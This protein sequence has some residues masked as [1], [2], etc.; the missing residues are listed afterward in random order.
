MEAY[1]CSS[2]L[3]TLM[4]REVYELL[5]IILFLFFILKSWFFPL[6]QGCVEAS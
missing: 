6:K 3:D 5:I 1:E 2:I 4:L